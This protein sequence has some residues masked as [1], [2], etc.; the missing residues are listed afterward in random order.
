[1][2][3][4]DRKKQSRNQQKMRPFQDVPGKRKNMYVARPHQ[5]F[6]TSSARLR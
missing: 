6:V 1:L 2:P 4:G 5:P 3:W